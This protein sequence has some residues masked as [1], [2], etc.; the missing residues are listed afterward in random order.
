M[1]HM[2]TNFRGMIL[3]CTLLVANHVSSAAS[4]SNREEYDSTREN[5]IKEFLDTNQN[6]WT[7]VTTANDSKPCKVDKRE[8][9]NSTHIYFTR[10]HR[11]STL[12]VFTKFYGEFRPNDPPYAVDVGPEGG[13]LDGTEELIY[14]GKEC[15]VFELRNKTNGLEY[16][17]YD[18]RIRGYG[19][20]Q[21]APE[22]LKWFEDMYPEE[23]FRRQLYFGSCNNIG[24]IR[25]VG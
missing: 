17:A 13:S 14:R 20:S 24:R 7:I 3:V 2:E 23:T 9:I 18:I 1:R 21:F 25:W 6:I 19:G 10:K 8:F 11:T 22:C 16:H 5:N 15:G 12:I 4:K